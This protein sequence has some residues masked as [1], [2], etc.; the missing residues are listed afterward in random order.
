MGQ[1]LFSK[2]GPLTVAGD[3][4]VLGWPL[5]V[6]LVLFTATAAAVSRVAGIGDWRAPIR[7]A[8][9]CVAQLA[10][11]SLVI[12]AVLGSMIWTTLF[13]AFMMAVAAC[14]G[15]RRVTGSVGVSALWMALPIAAG[16]L[17]VV[18]LAVGVGV[19]PAE[20]IAVLP[21]AGILV[22]G[23]MT[24]AVLAGRR[25]TEELVSQRGAYDAALA[26][27]F[28]RRESV[29]IV[30][31][32]SA[33]LALV[34]GLDQT[35]TVGLVTLPGAY[36]GVLLAGASPVEAGVAQGF[37]LIGLLAVQAIAAAVSVELVAAARI[38]SPGLV[39]QE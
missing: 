22:G 6:L 11:V 27:G 13:V 19:V 24:S 34:P 26:L 4:L 32:S 36:I 29:G 8:A 30:A 21:T 37:V 5:V 3:A 10:L 14:T 12:G 9:R 17:P 15:A 38:S 25:T 31:R 18:G 35:R 23:A 33:A 7:A 1:T 20:P 28:T 2:I 16:V 39:L